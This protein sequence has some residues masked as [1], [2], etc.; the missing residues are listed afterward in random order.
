MRSNHIL[1]K[2]SIKGPNNNNNN[3]RR[4]NNNNRNNNN[5]NNRGKQNQ[6]NQQQG[7]G[8]PTSSGPFIP[9]VV[10]NFI[11]YF[12][13]NILDREVY[14]LHSIY[15]NSFNKLTEKFFQKQRWPEAEEVAPL[16]DNDPVFLVLYRELYYRHVYSKLQ[17]S[18]EDRINSY[19]NYCD[20]FNYIL[21]GCSFIYFFRI[22][23]LGKRY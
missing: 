7:Q 9:E 2:F 1:L 5:N 13:R 12:H 22:T 21:S 16:V 14:E 11:F 18:I 4:Q 15:E 3:N 20:L 23:F 8:G 19:G 10:K 17:P 6:Q